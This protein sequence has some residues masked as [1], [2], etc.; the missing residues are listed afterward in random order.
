[1]TPEHPPL[2]APL[3]DVPEA[4]TDPRRLEALRRQ[5]ILDTPPEEA[6]DRL[7]RLAVRL[8]GLP[9]ALV[10]L[11]DA[12]R[13]FF[14][15]SI[16]IPEPWAE[17][18]ET[19]LSH[20][21]CQY[22]VGNGKPLVVRDARRHALL[23]HNA[24]VGELGTVAYAGYPL[25]A[26]GQVVGTFCAID[27]V[28]RDWPAD[29]IEVIADL[30][31]LAQSELDLRV[32]GRAARGSRRR[33]EEARELAEHAKAV[34]ESATEVL[35]R[36]TALTDVVLPAPDLGE[37]L[38]RAAAEVRRSFRAD[39]ALVAVGEE[40]GRFEHAASGLPARDE[41]VLELGLRLLAAVPEG[42]VAAFPDLGDD[43]RGSLR[44]VLA[45]PL[46]A[47]GRQA[48]LLLVASCSPRQWPELE[49]HLLKLGAERLAVALAQ[50]RLHD[51]ERLVAGT[52]QQALLPSHLPQVAGACL[53]A[54]FAP[55]EDPIGGDW[56]DAFALPGGRVG[57]AVG[58]VVGHGIESAAAAARL[59]H[60]LRGFVLCGHDP[61]G[62]I[63]GLD[64]LM[65]DEPHA[66]FSSVL[67]AELDLVHGRVQ[68]ATA[69]HVPPV[70]LRD[71]VA[72][73]LPSPGGT[74]LGVQ[75]ATP[76]PQRTDALQAGDRLVLY[77][78]GLVE[79]P[80]EPLDVAI[81]RIFAP[82]AAAATG[83]E[84]LCDALLAARPHPRRDDAAILAAAIL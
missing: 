27:D 34:A 42:E 78:D 26:E 25:F 54:R 32:A 71:G 48:G 75:S 74:L 76:W 56:Y 18:R 52:L 13:Q 38:R 59:R 51:R 72:R 7:T 15:S 5:E 55:A 17:R 65:D 46:R 9:V 68:W 43:A 23:R 39:A 67:Y 66:E 64:S 19:P 58:D 83:L 22:V 79:Q 84:G 82:A 2:T 10:S 40:G 31:A 21:F 29:D 16:G 4:V 12:D 49:R 81:E 63:A 57:L 20:S 77:T 8:L 30:A 14:K 41:T 3:Q 33:A 70:L 11:V 35:S 47:S 62:V 28:P 73:V 24:A 45:A 1:L 6:F 61:A 36:L 53:A 80:G 69:G 60:F 44:A 50:A 37:M